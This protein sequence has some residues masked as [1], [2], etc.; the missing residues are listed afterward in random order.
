MFPKIRGRVE[1]YYFS[2]EFP[3]GLGFMR[4]EINGMIHYFKTEDELMAFFSDITGLPMANLQIELF[5]Y[6]DGKVLMH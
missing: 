6:K 1:E 4:A 5:A 2:L 3:T